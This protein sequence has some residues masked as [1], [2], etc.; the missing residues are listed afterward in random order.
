MGKA[1]LSMVGKKFFRVDGH[2]PGAPIDVWLQSF[3][4]ISDPISPPPFMKSM[5]LTFLV[6]IGL[7]K[8]KG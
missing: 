2:P 1:Q 4:R 7:L 5:V 8:D 3:E 6:S